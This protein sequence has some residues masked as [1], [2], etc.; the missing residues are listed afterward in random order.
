[1]AE[2]GDLTSLPPD[3]PVPEDDGACAHLHGTRLPA[4][5]LSGTRGQDVDLSTLAGRSVV[6]AYPMT[7]VPGQ[8]LPES[9]DLIP[10]AR[11]CTPQSCAFRDRHA[12]L[13]ALGATV[14]GL[15]TNTNEH[16]REAAKRLQLPFELLSDE[17]MGFTSALALPTFEV[18]GMTLLKRFTLIVSNGT[19]EHVLYP[20]FPSDR[21]ASDVIDWLGAQPG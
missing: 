5:A 2:P 19:I 1:M 9:W 8:P 15:S 12:E 13:Q 11:G 6:Y 16:Q 21:N 7:G 3:L 18:E 14:F 17:R 10:G 4:L 20:V